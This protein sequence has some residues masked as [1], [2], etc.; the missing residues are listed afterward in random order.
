[1]SKYK[2]TNKAIEDLNA[3]WNYTFDKWSEKQADKYYFILLE[4]CQNLADQPNLGRTY[5][6]IKKE[7]LGFKV[8]RHII[9]YRKLIDETIEIIR[10]LHQRMDLENRLNE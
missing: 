8:N 9:F 3:I 7:L 5:N 1:M 6:D 10:I 4:N 2:L